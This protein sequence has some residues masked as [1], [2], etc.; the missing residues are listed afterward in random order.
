MIQ[1]FPEEWHQTIMELQED[2]LFNEVTQSFFDSQR[3][4]G[5]LR[6]RNETY[7][8]KIVQLAEQEIRQQLGGPEGSDLNED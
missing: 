8:K 6:P 2:E 1:L 7:R 5:V 4:E 3:V